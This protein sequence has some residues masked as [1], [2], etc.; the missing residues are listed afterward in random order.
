MGHPRIGQRKRGPLVRG[1]VVRGAGKD[2]ADQLLVQPFIPGNCQAHR[3]SSAAVVVVGTSHAHDLGRDGVDGRQADHR[4]GE[5]FERPAKRWI[6]G[7]AA[8]DAL[9]ARHT[10]PISQQ[11]VPDQAQADPLLDNQQCMDEVLHPF[12]TE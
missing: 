11:A 1:E 10:S 2:I 6:S 5:A 8:G 4:C 3:Q 7:R 12:V 9:R